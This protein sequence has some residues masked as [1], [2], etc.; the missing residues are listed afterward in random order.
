MS[1]VTFKVPS[2]SLLEIEK[3]I[4]GYFVLGQNVSLDDISGLTGIS[5]T[6]LSPNH[7]FLREVGIIQGGVKK[8]ATP[9]GSELGNAIHHKLPEEVQKYW[10]QIVK[11]NDFLSK[12]SSTVRIKKGMTPQ[13]LASHILYVAKVAD[14]KSNRTG[15]NAILDILIKSGILKELDGKLEYID[16]LPILPIKNEVAKLDANIVDESST[17]KSKQQKSSDTDGSFFPNLHIDIQIHI[18]SS[19]S[20]EQIDQIFIS[21]S[22][23]L[24]KLVKSK[25]E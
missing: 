10:K 6:T 3:I 7:P 14:N 11:D 25:N 16:S 9:L 20:L 22:T 23:H 15:A 17:D 4:D 13:E 21:M 12:V 19:C 18:D 1:K 24:S 5:K 2:S 8:S